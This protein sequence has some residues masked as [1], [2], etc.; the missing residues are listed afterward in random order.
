MVNDV[1]VAF[2]DQYY[3]LH[4]TTLS[5]SAADGLLKNDFDAND[6]PLTVS[7]VSGPS[8]GA[9]TLASDGSF[10]FVPTAGFVGTDSFTY[11]VS[12]GLQTSASASAPSR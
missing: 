12:D 2:A 5:V 10:T 3:G 7:L 9:L 6:D 1:P 8:N 4:D 11:T